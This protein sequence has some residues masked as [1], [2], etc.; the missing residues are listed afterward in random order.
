[1]TS[2][3]WVDTSSTRLR[4]IALVALTVAGLLLT[5]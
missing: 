2:K 3:S 5:G 1:M 4:R